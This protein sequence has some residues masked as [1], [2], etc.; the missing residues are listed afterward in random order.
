M[1]KKLPAPET[2]LPELVE[3][4]PAQM[5]EVQNSAADLEREEILVLGRNLGHLELAT[6]FRDISEAGMLSAYENVKKSKAWRSLRSK[7][8]EIFP[9]LDAFCQERLGYSER[10]L[11]QITDNR[12][13][14]GQAAFEHAEKIGLRQADYNVIKALPAPKQEI[15]KEALTDGASKEEVQRALRELAAADQ[16]EIESL[17]NERDSVK[18]EH[19]A[20]ERVL[21]DKQAKIGKLEKQLAKLQ[22]YTPDQ[23]AADLH[24]KMVEALGHEMHAL[25]GQI[26]KVATVVQD[27]Y[28]TG[29]TTA[30]EGV[31]EVVRWA[32]QSLADVALKH[33]IEVDFKEIVVPEWMRPMLAGAEATSA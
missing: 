4:A 2:R 13:A 22:S 1:A 28:A 9:N 23:T 31:N 18:A 14:I 30:I 24:K 8:G 10:R 11:R 26:A 29:D 21:E 16:K 32:F 20:I 33:G 7:S 19:E 25:H 3:D 6:F 5:L 27:V 15:I 17:T 12:E